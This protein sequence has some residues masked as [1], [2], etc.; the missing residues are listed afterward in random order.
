MSVLYRPAEGLRAVLHGVGAVHD[1]LAQQLR[2]VGA[3][4]PVIVCGSSV[5]ATPLVDLVLGA[6]GLP[7]PV[8]TG[9]LPHTPASTIDEGA[10]YAFSHGA[11]S[12][13]AIGGSSAIDCAKGIAVLLK[14]VK[15]SVTELEVAQFG[16]LGETTRRAVEPM[17]LICIPTTLSMAEFQSFFGARDTVTR[18]KNPY[19]DH[20]LVQRTV[21]LDG[22]IAAHTPAGLWAETGVKCLDDAISRYCATPDADPAADQLLEH[23]VGELCSTLRDPSFGSGRKPAQQLAEPATRQ[24]TFL[25]AWR[26]GFAVPRSSGP[27]RR[28]WFSTTAR[29]ALGGAFELPHGVG[30][31]VSLVSGLRFHLSTTETRQR[32]LASAIEPAAGDDLAAA[33][34]RLLDQ[35]AVPRRLGPLGIERQR[36]DDVVANMR[37]EAPSLATDEQLLQICSSFW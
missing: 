18:R 31:C 7:A 10:A 27:I 22:E 34:S 29:H 21:I 9:S 35:L 14:L 23:A 24:R 19:L 1:G 17:P 8:F 5:A 20:G 11:D 33:V 6:V 3:A 37:H 13:I 12:I 32:S 25:A 16:R 4:R 30:S 15:H 28:P 26:T 36:I 2:E